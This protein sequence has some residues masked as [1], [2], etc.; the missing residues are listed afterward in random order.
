MKRHEFPFTWTISP[1]GKTIFSMAERYD[2]NIFSSFPSP[3]PLTPLLPSYTHFFFFRL[4]F[5][6]RPS[7]V[8]NLRKYI[9][10]RSLSQDYRSFLSMCGQ[11]NLFILLSRFLLLSG[12]IKVDGL[13]KKTTKS[14]YSSLFNDD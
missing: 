2:N 8:C 1:T 6:P 4:F 3:V 5:P 11:Y 9:F 10:F 7:S 14:R 13:E 12:R